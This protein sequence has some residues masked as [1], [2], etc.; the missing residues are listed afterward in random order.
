MPEDGQFA[1][2]AAKSR[3]RE[4][5]QKIHHRE[6]GGKQKVGKELQKAS[7]P[8]RDRRRSGTNSF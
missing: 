3:S 6:H 1:R 7:K 8:G 4:E 5:K 2:E